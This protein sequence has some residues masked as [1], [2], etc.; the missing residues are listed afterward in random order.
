MDLS[1]TNTITDP[2]PGGGAVR[3]NPG[4]SIDPIIGTECSLLINF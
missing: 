1:T 3:V 4:R 2:A